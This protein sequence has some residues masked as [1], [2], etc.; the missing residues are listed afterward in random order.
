MT[1][2]VTKLVELLE[3]GRHRCHVCQWYCELRNEEPGRCLMRE[4]TEDGIAVLNHAI[5]SAA[6][7]ALIE[8]FRLWH[9]FPDSSVL[10]LGSW[11]Y[12]FPSDQQHGQYARIPDDPQKQRQLEPERVALVALERLCRGIIWAYSDPCIAQEYVS[13]V[14]R[15]CKGNSRYTALVSNGYFTQEALDSFGRYLDGLNIEIRAFDDSAYKLLAGI[16]H[17]RGILEVTERAK[18]QWQCHIEITTRLHPSVNDTPEQLNGLTN[19][20]AETLGVQTPWHI[21]PGDAGAAAAAA[22]QRARKSAHA[23]GLQYVYS[24]DT[25]QSTECPKCSA[26]VIDRSGTRARIVGMQDGG[27][28]ACGEPLGMRT[29]I[30]RR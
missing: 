14:L 21:L 10:A 16:E 8:D 4:G 15:T 17:W 13:D 9:F 24:S 7:V 26:V 22:V 20:I 18:K 2:G 28:S 19:W 30:F 1:L 23:A 3:D 5:V 12:A 11:G 29:S 6:Q 25:N 27:C